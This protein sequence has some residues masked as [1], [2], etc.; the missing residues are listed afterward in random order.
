MADFIQILLFVKMLK[1]SKKKRKYFKF[2]WRKKKNLLKYSTFQHEIFKKKLNYSTT[3]CPSW[4]YMSMV[5]NSWCNVGGT[6][7][8]CKM[9]PLFK[10][11]LFK[12]IKC[13][14]KFLQ[15]LWHP[16]DCHI[17]HIITSSFFFVLEFYQHSRYMLYK[18]ILP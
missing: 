7:C 1:F 3:M 4:P 11:A 5:G 13:P 10:E 12:N 2:L 14:T 16:R 15:M 6:S 8:K 18:I 17:I 9:P